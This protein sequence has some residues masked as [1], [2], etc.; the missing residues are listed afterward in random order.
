MPDAK[1]ILVVEDEDMVADVVERYLRRDGYEVE[2][3]HD[4]AAGLAAYR[5]GAPDLVVLDV[6]LPGI[7][8]LEVCQRIREDGATPVIL[9]TARD[10][11]AD[12]INGLGLGADDYVTKPF[13]PREL[14]ARVEAVLRRTAAPVR[15]ADSAGGHPLRFGDLEVDAVKRTVLLRG[16][17]VA[18]TAREFDLLAYLAEHPGRVFSREQLMDAIWDED[19]EGDAGTVTVHVRRL[20]TKIEQDP[21][22]PVYLRTVWGVGYKFEG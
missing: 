8:G 12:K 5:R 13:S 17:P 4:G 3:A 11:E 9:L 2:V 18:L 10:R 19:F 22:R 16:E 15:T 20:R 21:S 6:M 1:R 7:D 14:V